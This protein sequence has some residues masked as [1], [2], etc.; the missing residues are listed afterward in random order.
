VELKRSLATLACLAAIAAP[1]GPLRAQSTPPASQK[2]QITGVISAP[3][4]TRLAIAI[5]PFRLSPVAPAAVRDAAAEVHDTVVAD[6]SFSGYFDVVP[7]ERYAA[8]P[9]EAQPIPFAAWAATNAVALLT[10]AVTPDAD[11]LSLEGL[12]F[13]TGGGQLI[14]G[15][16]YR[17][18]TAVARLIGHRLANE[19]VLHFTGR[20]GIFLSRIAVEG[21]VGKT[22]E[23]FVLDYDG[24]GLRQVTRNGSLNVA[25]TLSPDGTK[26]AFV[27]YKSGRPR[28]YVLAQD[29]PMTDVSPPGVDL[30]SAPDWSPDGKLLA[31]SASK[32]ADSDIYVL[33][34][35]AGRSRKITFTPSIETSPSWSPSGR[36]IAFTSDRTGKPQVYVMDAEGANVRRVTLEGNYNDQPAWSP[37]GD[38]LAYAGWV[39]DHFDIFVLDVASGA[40]QRLTSLAGFNENPRWSA[41]GRHIAFASNRN[42][43]YQVYTMDSNGNGVLKLPTPFEA[44][45]P[46]WSR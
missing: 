41:D 42:G 4:L 24:K 28:L 6:L 43:I 44:W 20:P 22:K 15:K 7:Q 12:L 21:R 17:G 26:I 34:V 39:D 36:E 31:F 40:A 37:Q 38:R 46:D 11:R 29:G 19:I 1:A 5:P 13:D 23:I 27:S 18:E 45:G 2:G 9:L 30:C 32:E 35:G 25:P 33:D 14:L 16:R 10:A 3:G 8:I